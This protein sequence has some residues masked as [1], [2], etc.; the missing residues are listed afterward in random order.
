MKRT[1]IG[2]YGPSNLD[3][4]EGELFEN[5][6]FNNFKEPLL[7]WPDVR[8]APED[9]FVEQTGT[10]KG[11]ASL[12]VAMS[13]IP[14]IMPFSSCSADHERCSS[15]VPNVAFWAKTRKALEVVQEAARRASVKVSEI[16]EGEE[17]GFMA[18][19]D[20]ASELPKL[21]K[22]AEEAMR[23]MDERKMRRCSLSRPSQAEFDKLFHVG[24]AE[25][26]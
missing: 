17:L 13:E 5:H 23:V 18:Y 25:I 3:E 16:E 7:Q 26:R 24:G 1:S 22:M 8:K 9:F 4:L 11:V 20:S 14:N 10:D 19:V 6:E 15:N 21:R 2:N 12:V